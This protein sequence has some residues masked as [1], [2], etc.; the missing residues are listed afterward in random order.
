MSE[1][2]A[3]AQEKAIDPESGLLEDDI[4]TVVMQ[5]CVTREKAIEALKAAD[6]DLVD[7]VMNLIS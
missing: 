5:A 1:V 7:A 4:K 3:P 6:G 2:E